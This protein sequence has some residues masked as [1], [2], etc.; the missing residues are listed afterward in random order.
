MRK[1]FKPREY[2]VHCTCP[3]CGK[4]FCPAP[5]HVYEDEHGVY[6]SW[7]CFNHRNEVARARIRTRGQ[8]GRPVE[9]LTL[10]GELVN[11]FQSAEIAAGAINVCSVSIR[12]AC[13]AYPKPFKKYLWRFKTDNDD[14]RIS[15]GSTED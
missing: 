14:Q 1:R 5:Y 9:Q 12:K 13:K 10:E 4:T 7:T 6:C 8:R 15:E 2:I 3:V 11:A